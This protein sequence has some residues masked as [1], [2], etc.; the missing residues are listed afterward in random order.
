[1]NE[2]NAL[3]QDFT[4]GVGSKIITTSKKESDVFVLTEESVDLIRYIALVDRK[5]PNDVL[6][7]IIV[8][9]FMRTVLKPDPTMSNK[10]PPEKE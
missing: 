7:D 9:E 2:S 1:M 10:I 4:Q 3:S 5:T 6:N 8:N